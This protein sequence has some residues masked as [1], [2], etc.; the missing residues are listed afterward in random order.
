[1]PGQGGR[2]RRTRPNGHGHTTGH[3]KTDEKDVL[4]R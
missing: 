3:G 1:M 4:E 2:Q